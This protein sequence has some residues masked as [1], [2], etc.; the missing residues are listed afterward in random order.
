MPLSYGHLCAVQPLRRAYAGHVQPFLHGQAER[1]RAV[2]RL[3]GSEC[4]VGA[5]QH[6]HALAAK[7]GV[8]CLSGTGQG[9]QSQ[10]GRGGVA[11][12]RRA[13]GAQH[14]KGIQFGGLRVLRRGGARD[15]QLHIPRFYGI[16]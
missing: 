3:S 16:V 10:C 11:D 13:G 14:V 9:G 4:A 2:E 7:V 1:Q 15:N 8:K 5:V 6:E 12:A